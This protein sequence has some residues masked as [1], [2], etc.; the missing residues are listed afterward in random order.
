MSRF[1]PWAVA[2]RILSPRDGSDRPLVA[3][4][5]N[6]TPD[7]FHDGGHH[8]T[9]G[10][11]LEHA[12]RLLE[13][14]A[15][16]LDVGG[17]STRPGADPV[18]PAEELRRV[19]PVVE[20]LAGRG[21]AVSIDTRRPEVAEAALA[22]GACAVNDIEGLRDPRMLELCA[23]YGAGACAMH[24]RGAPRD[25]QQDTRYADLEA[26]V[27]EFLAEAAA[28]WS[29]AG[30]DPAALALDPGVGF[31]KDPAQ[32]LALVRA[33]ARFR[34]RFPEHAWYLGLSRKS[35]VGRHPGTR[36]GSD[37]LAGSLGAAL[38]GAALGADLLRVHDV[39]ATLESWNLFRDCGGVS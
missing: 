7:S 38:A 18:P 10:Q 37:R 36:G 22:A 3:G 24:M 6:V 25:M 23:R 39:A 32:N 27:A 26:E 11:A 29:D 4:I 1:R 16:M 9:P 35:F 30:L 5:L 8:A 14:G 21:V 33:T 15:D 2:G 20:A 12:G 19:L 13:E 17:E 28:R 34:A 31:G